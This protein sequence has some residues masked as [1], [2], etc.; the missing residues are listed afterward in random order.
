MVGGRTRPGAEN[1]GIIQS[2]GLLVQSRGDAGRGHVAEMRTRRGD[3][4]SGRW[5]TWIESRAEALDRTATPPAPPHLPEG[6][7]AS[8]L[9]AYLAGWPVV[10]GG[11]SALA[12]NTSWRRSQQVAAGELRWTSGWGGR[13]GN[14]RPIGGG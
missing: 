9:R 5:L 8:D 14:A 12:P 7:T 3:D 4:D 1:R 2:R 10:H 11:G 6:L 13:G